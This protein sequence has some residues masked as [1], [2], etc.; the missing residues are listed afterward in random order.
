MFLNINIL[1]KLFNDISVKNVFLPFWSENNPCL[2]VVV[3]REMLEEIS[4]V[5]LWVDLIFGFE[6]NGI[7]AQNILNLYPRYSYEKCLS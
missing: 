1:N 5:N 4:N 7:K 3:C 2:F 6:S